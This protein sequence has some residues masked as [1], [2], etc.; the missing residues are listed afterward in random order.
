[1]EADAV[2]PIDTANLLTAQPALCEAHPEAA[3]LL[4]R[5]AVRL[6][7][8]LVGDVEVLCGGHG[9]R[10]ED[11]ALLQERCQHVH[12][13]AIIAGCLADFFRRLQAFATPLKAPLH[14][15]RQDTRQ[16]AT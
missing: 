15:P 5:L 7:P 2:P 6:A 13:G 8:F 12:L 4:D 9:I 10:T 3:L 16:L 11:A 1:M 14:D